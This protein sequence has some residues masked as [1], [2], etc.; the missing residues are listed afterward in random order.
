MSALKKSLASGE[1]KTKETQSKEKHKSNSTQ[2][3][4]NSVVSFSS[5]TIIELCHRTHNRKQFHRLKS[6]K[7][8]GK[9]FH[10]K[11]FYQFISFT[12]ILELSLSTKLQWNETIVS[13]HLIVSFSAI[14]RVCIV[15]VYI[16]TGFSSI[17]YAVL[18]LA[19]HCLEMN[20]PFDINT[21]TDFHVIPFFIC[22]F[23]DCS[24]ALRTEMPFGFSL[25]LSLSLKSV[26]NRA[27]FNF[28]NLYIVEHH[29]RVPIY[30][31]LCSTAVQ[32]IE[33]YERFNLYLSFIFIETEWWK[34]QNIK[35]QIK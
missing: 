28:L 1:K 29:H 12:I 24:L 16:A 10:N 15:C 11:D 23:P 21:L 35:F 32:M 20:F 14:Y 2:N 30:T 33:I 31:L 26:S 7:Q 3:A 22:F 25:A 5:Y 6:Q 18:I 8:W 34:G 19:L 27:R 4:I 17:V 13:W 9:I